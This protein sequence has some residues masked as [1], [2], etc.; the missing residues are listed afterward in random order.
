MGKADN[1]TQKTDASV[2]A[3]LAAIEPASRRAD[4]EALIPLMSEVTGAPARMWGTSMVGFGEY[5]YRYDSGREG[6]SFLAGFASRK[7]ALTIYLMGTYCDEDRT[8]FE[9]LGKF[10]TGKAC[11]Y[12]KSLADIDLAVLRRLLVASV[13]ALRKR[14]G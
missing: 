12:V 14:H 11:L 8:L 5:H 9:Q 1:K 6:D 3:Y 13:A 7:Q 4:C 2:A 10:K